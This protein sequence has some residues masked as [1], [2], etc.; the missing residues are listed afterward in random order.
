MNLNQN[1]I[2][3]IVEAQME[4][5]FE[6]AETE[7]M[8]EY[9]KISMPQAR[10]LLRTALAT[11]QLDQPR[12]DLNYIES[13]VQSDAEYNSLDIDQHLEIVNEHRKAIGYTI[14]DLDK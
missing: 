1:E 6:D 5:L 13:L 10:G 3:R 12:I 2:D 8:F 9:I 4:L 11:V 7:T 14:N